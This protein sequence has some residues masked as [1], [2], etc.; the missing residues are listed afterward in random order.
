MQNLRNKVVVVTGASAGIGRAIAIAFAREGA[1]VAVLAR[2]KDRLAGVCRQIKNTCPAQAFA[3]PTD[4]ADYEQV[5]IAAERA[6]KILGPIDVWINNAM[7]TVFSPFHDMTAEEFRR[8]TEV[9]YLGTV[10]GTMAALKRMRPRNHGHIVQIG[11]ALAYQAIPLQ[12]AY[13]GAK[14]AI[15]GFSNAIRA[16]LLHDKIDI[17]V[18]M[19]QLGAFNTPQFEWARAKLKYHPQ[20]LPPI[21]QPELAATATLEAVKQRRREVWVGFSSTKAIVGGK[22]FPGLLERYL[23]H[24]AYEGQCTDEILEQSREGNLFETVRGDY[25]IYGRFGKKSRDNSLQL[26]M[27]LHRAPVITGTVAVIIGVAI[28]LVFGIK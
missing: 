19:I 15:R 12:S 2:D 14:H 18:S 21:F 23:A 11:S 9:T 22:L 28:A 27:S 24:K 16:E 13:C 10:Y 7:V 26:W 17:A 1:Q 20:P 3:L 6:E 4:V 8:V 25:G 5:E